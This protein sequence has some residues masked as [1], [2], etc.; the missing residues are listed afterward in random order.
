MTQLRYE[1]AKD[2][3]VDYFRELNHACYR[4]LV[5]RQFGPWEPSFQDKN[6]DVKWQTQKFLKVYAASELAGGVWVDEHPDYRR[7][8]E[9]Q[10]HPDHQSRGI[11]TAV[12]LSVIQESD[13][14]G[15][16]VRLHVLHENQAVSLY[17]RLGFVTIERTDTQFVMLRPKT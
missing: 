9:I 4:D 3:D 14:Q 5:E 11:G 7:L 10:I 17:E 2:E 15:L 16:P 12:I 6:F 13:A 8:R 1:P